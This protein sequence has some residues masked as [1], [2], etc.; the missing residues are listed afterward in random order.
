MCFSYSSPDARQSISSTEI[1]IYQ[2][3]NKLI[4]QSIAFAILAKIPPIYGLYSAII[5][6]IIISLF[7]SSS[8]IIGGPTTATCI[9]I[10]G[11]LA[12]YINLPTG[13]YMTVVFEFTQKFMPR[14]VTSS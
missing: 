13:S 12:A 8:H 7:S 2:L 3:I 1:L 6:T 10:A 14:V 4:P 9:L 5:G 11:S